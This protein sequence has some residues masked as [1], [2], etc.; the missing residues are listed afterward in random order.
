MR[1]IFG[2]V[3]L[4]GSCCSAAAVDDLYSKCA[5]KAKSNVDYNACGDGLLKRDDDRLNAAWKSALAA[6]P[7]EDSRK[8]LLDEQR[9][10]NA[11]KEKSCMIYATSDFGR[12]GQVINYPTCRADVIEA[13][14]K[15]LKTLKDN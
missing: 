8:A 12:E 11:Y 5:E 1:M 7:G 6:M 2:L 10:W 14:T 13:R 9:A 3:L 15:Y 4:L